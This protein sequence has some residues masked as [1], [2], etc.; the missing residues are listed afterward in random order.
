MIHGVRVLDVAPGATDD[1]RNFGL[2]V[3]LLGPLRNSG[4]RAGSDYCRAA[5]LDEEEG[6]DLLFIDR[7]SH[8]GGVVVIISTS[9]PNRA[10]VR[11]RRQQT[12]ACYG[13]PTSASIARYC[14]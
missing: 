13:L 14:T 7:S 1:D 8:L 9:T 4:R 6:L 3:D 2:P 5:R 12:G 11:H 10:D